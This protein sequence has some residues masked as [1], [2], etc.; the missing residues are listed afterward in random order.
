MDWGRS[1]GKR[2]GARVPQT[3]IK[4]ENKEKGEIKVKKVKGRYN[5]WKKK[6]KRKKMDWGRSRAKRKSAKVEG[7]KG[8]EY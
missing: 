2:K 5:K 3:K 1:R 4:A 6:E 8:K 7:K